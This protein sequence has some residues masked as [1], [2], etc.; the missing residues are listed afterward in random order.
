MPLPLSSATVGRLFL[1]AT[2][3]FWIAF[4]YCLWYD[5]R[6]ILLL[7]IFGWQVDVSK[8]EYQP[9][10]LS[11]IAAFAM[12]AW[13]AILLYRRS[14]SVHQKKPYTPSPRSR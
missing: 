10:S 14:V 3:L 12:T 11:L 9:G 8:L 13:H 2:L 1:A 4:L 7:M 5:A 6:L